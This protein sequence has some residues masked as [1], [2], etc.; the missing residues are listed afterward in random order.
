MECVYLFVFG[1]FAKDA[2]AIM[3]SIGF[4]RLLENNIPLAP[5]RVQEPHVPMALQAHS[6]E[7]GGIEANA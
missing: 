5:K 2:V 1:G 6:R 3:M 7:S 4:L